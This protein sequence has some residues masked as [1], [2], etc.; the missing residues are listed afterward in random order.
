MIITFGCIKGGV[1]KSTLAFNVAVA[2]SH[3]AETLVIDADKQGT[4]SDFA[5]IRADNHEGD[6]G[7]TSIRSHGNEVRSQVKVM[8][9]KFDRIIIDAGG[10]DSIALRIAYTMSDVV[11]IPIPPR[12]AEVLAVPETI[13]LVEEARAFN[14]KL[15]P[16]FVVSQA[17]A[18]GTD[19]DDLIKSL[20]EDY[21]DIPVC[22]TVLPLRK[23]W[24]A[25]IAKGRS[26][27]EP[28]KNSA[29]RA[30]FSEFLKFIEELG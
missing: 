4:L 19:N 22:S 13:E 18:Q 11:V 6:A 9:R 25:Q 8:Q 21:P 26:V 15:R 24:S 10:K 5:Q 30:E 23:I 14:E 20:K 29:V 27:M 17:D 2:W 28:P 12:S 3:D 1:G 16:C 7:F